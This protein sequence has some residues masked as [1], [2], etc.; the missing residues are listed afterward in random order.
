MATT[1][2]HS[3]TRR[4]SASPS[5]TGSSSGSANNSASATSSAVSPLFPSSSWSDPLPPGPTT[6]DVGPFNGSPPGGGVG[7]GGSI[8]SST[9][10][11]RASFHFRFDCRCAA[12]DSFPFLFLLLSLSYRCLRLCTSPSSTSSFLPHCSLAPCLDLTYL[13]QRAHPVYTF[14]ATLILLLGVSSAIVFRSILL[15]RR[16]RRMVAEAIANGTWNPP[17]PRV[18]VDLRKKPRLWDAWVAPPLLS[19]V[20]GGG[21]KDDWDGI[22]VGCRFF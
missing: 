10:L 18:R 2:P 14:L 22:M 20:Q 6:S 15:R 11:Y 5:R 4:S 1:T 7:A 16:H 13:K 19:V 9:K 8:Q 21:E 3:S 12:A 17:A